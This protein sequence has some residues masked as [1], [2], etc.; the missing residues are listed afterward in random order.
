MIL[1]T[2][3][4]FVVLIVCFILLKVPFSDAVVILVSALVTAVLYSWFL[5]WIILR[6][7]YPQLGLTEK[8]ESEKASN[9]PQEDACISKEYVLEY[10]D[11]HQ[12]V[13]YDY[14]HSNQN[15]RT[16]EVVRSFLIPLAIFEIIMAIV[17]GLI[18]NNQWSSFA[19]FCG[20]GALLTLIVYIFGSI[21]RPKVVRAI[22][23]QKY[24]QYTSILIGKHKVSV[25]SSGLTDARKDGGLKISWGN[26]ERITSSKKY[27][28]FAI[29]GSAPIIAPKRAFTNDG[30]F[31]EFI[32]LAKAY[33]QANVENKL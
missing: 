10:K 13:C 27:L 2:T 16:L 30:E 31:N 19:V 3:F 4:T 15:R 23:N 28:F 24:G 5:G 32:K 7:I 9:P 26:I 14:Y 33:Y 12:A 18:W 1:G 17:F 20:I 6:F 29:K 21:L 25:S 8:T 11:L 22:I